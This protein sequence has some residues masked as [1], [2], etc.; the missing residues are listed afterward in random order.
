MLRRMA[1][2]TSSRMHCCNTHMLELT[3][4][5]RREGGDR[6]TVYRCE[7]CGRIDSLGIACT[8]WWVGA[9]ARS[10]VDLRAEAFH[11]AGLEACPAAAVLNC[12]NLGV[13][14]G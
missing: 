1:D 2:D 12:A 10:F 5:E 11:R 3:M 14:F 7:T 13:I 8:P 6:V 9:R 4:A